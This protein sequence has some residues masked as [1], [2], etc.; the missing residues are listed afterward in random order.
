MT[1]FLHQ[2]WYVLGAFCPWLL[3]GLMIAGSLH[4]LLPPDF[5]RRHLGRGGLG[6]VARAALF[7]VPLPLCSCGV[8]PATVGLKK[9]GASD[10]AAVAFL[11]STPQT[12]VDSIA[13]SSV[14]LGWP[15]ALFKV[16]TAFITG[17]LA[18]WLVEV[19]GPR[20]AD[21]ATAPGSARNA[22]AHGRG[23]RAGVLE[24]NR[25]VFGELFGSIWKWILIGVLV[26]ALISTFFPEN[27]LAHVA[28]LRGPGGMLLMLLIALPMYV[29]ATGSVPIAASLVTAGL[30]PGSA[31]VFLMAGPATN[32]ATMGAVYKTFGKRVLAIYL[33]VLIV[34]SLL[35]GY[36][37]DFLLGPGYRAQVHCHGDTSSAADSAWAAIL[38]LILIAYASHDRYRWWSRS[39]LAATAPVAAAGAGILRFQV[40][41]MSCQNCARHVRDTALA[42]SGV[43]AATVD[44]DKHLLTVEGDPAAADTV[45]TVV[46]AAGY[47]TIQT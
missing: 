21:P 36:S 33:G 44:L 13:V 12:G 39:R 30:P 9:D 24:F 6:S 14:F 3:L 11:V 25:F 46:T 7:G 47:P 29:C 23:W 4:V 43:T 35:F 42:V 40:T 26:S 41:G 38:A 34:A 8:I 16:V 10:G 45:R 19:T 27:S 22:A 31:L 1:T 32:A 20:Q 2:L 5:V 28:W 37:F 17:L 18:G 15:F